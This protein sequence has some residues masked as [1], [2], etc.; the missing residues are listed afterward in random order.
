MRGNSIEFEKGGTAP[1]AKSKISHHLPALIVI[2]VAVLVQLRKTTCSLVCL[3]SDPQ[4]SMSVM[5]GPL[6]LVRAI[7]CMKYNLHAQN[8]FRVRTERSDKTLQV[9]G[10]VELALLY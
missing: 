10:M 7:P 3:I 1:D 5:E 8:Q 6:N 2:I 9:V 4:V